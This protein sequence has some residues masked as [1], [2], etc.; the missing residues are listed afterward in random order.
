LGLVPF[1]LPEAET[2]IAHGVLIEYSGTLLAAYR[3]MRDMLLFTLPFFLIITYLGGFSTDGIHPLYG[4]VEYIGLVALLTVSRN[5]NPRIRIDQVVKFFWGPL[6]LL[7]M[8][9]VILALRNH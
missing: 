8:I 6:T 5:V 2:E 4:I 7:A 1:D 9:A 3:L